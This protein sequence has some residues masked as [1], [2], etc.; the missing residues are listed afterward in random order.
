MREMEPYTASKNTVITRK[1]KEFKNMI[2][3]GEQERTSLPEAFSTWRE[4]EAIKKGRKK[5]IKGAQNGS[6]F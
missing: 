4:K 5:N 6:K 2:T 3:L 1:Q